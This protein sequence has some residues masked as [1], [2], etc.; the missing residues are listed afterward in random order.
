MDLKAS[1]IKGLISIS[2]L[3]YYWYQE[4]SMQIVQVFQLLVPWSAYNM[5]KFSHKSIYFHTGASGHWSNGQVSKILWIHKLVVIFHNFVSNTVSCQPFCFLLDSSI[6]KWLFCML[7][8][9]S[10]FLRYITVFIRLHNV[11]VVVDNQNCT[12]VT[13]TSDC[14]YSHWSHFF[15]LN[16]KKDFY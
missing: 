10:T 4:K 3:L 8:W 14:V 13:V 6:Q 5:S 1:E 2:V 9:A 11:V 12:I 7:Q 15:Y 16:Y